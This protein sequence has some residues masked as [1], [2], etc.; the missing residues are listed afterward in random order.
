[1]ARS[2]P[3]DLPAA[4]VVV[5]HVPPAGTS[6]LPAILD[7]V[8]AL[9]VV[10]AGGGEPL[11][12]GAGHAA[13]RGGA[14]LVKR[15]RLRQVRGPTENGVR[16]AVDPLFRSAAAA[17]GPRTV[18]VIL[19]GALDDGTEGLLRIHERGGVTMVL[20]PGDGM[21]DGM[22]RSAIENVPVDH[23]VGLAELG[24]VLA[25]VASEPLPAG[26]EQAAEGEPEELDPVEVD[27]AIS[28]ADLPGNPSGFTCPACD[29]VLWETHEGEFLRFRCRVGHAFSP[30][31]LLSEQSGTIEEALWAG[32]RALEE[33]ATLQARLAGRAR[34]R[35]QKISAGRFESMARAA[36][37]RASVLRGMLSGTVLAPPAA[38]LPVGPV[39]GIRSAD[40][41]AREQVETGS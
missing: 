26:A 4:V 40:A 5:M 3:A 24:E 2:L 14:L 41:E 6:A 17:Y 10:A 25:R 13:P 36:R 28:E 32:I 22:P 37:E 9:P 38:G 31:S 33:N 12:P 19:S 35:G 15:G 18:G 11:E 21:F 30:E 23:V 1:M 34:E 20:D 16:P 27:A 8:C 39:T 29:G 7:R